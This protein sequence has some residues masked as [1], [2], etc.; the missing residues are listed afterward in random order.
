MAS[1]T[2]VNGLANALTVV[3][4]IIDSAQH[5]IAFLAPPSILSIGGASFNSMQSAKRFIQRGGVF[6]GVTTVSLVNLE[7]VR[8]RLNI[9][10]N[11]RHSDFYHEVF[12][13]VGDK[14]HSLS[15]ANVGIYDYR[16]DTPV[17]TYCSKDPTYVEYLLTSFEG[18]WS[19][20]VPAEERLLELMGNRKTALH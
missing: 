12:M 5:E 20:S 9:G 13:I 6:K 10:E 4:N 7:E 1:G 16:L 19:Q 2:I 3:V 17:I 14:Q 11:L 15:A 8:M 18:A